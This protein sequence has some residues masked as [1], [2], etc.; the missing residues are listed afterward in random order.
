MS[1]LADLLHRVDVLTGTPPPQGHDFTEFWVWWQSVRGQ[2]STLDTEPPPDAVV[3]ALDQRVRRIDRRLAWELGP[4]VHRP[5]AL[6]VSPDGHDDLRPVTAAWRAAA[7]ADRHFDF[8]DTRP[9]VPGPAGELV[10][11]VPEGEIFGND[12]QV[13]VLDDAAHERLDLWVYH[14]ALK[15]TRGPRRLGLAGIL[16]DA[17]LGESD[18]ATWVGI[19][20]PSPEPLGERTELG[21]QAQ[22]IDLDTLRTRVKQ[23]A[24]AGDPPC[25][26]PLPDRTDGWLPLPGRRRWQHPTL[27]THLRLRLDGAPNA[28]S[29]LIAKNADR[30]CPVAW[31]ATS[32]ACF[33]DLYCRASG[34][35][36][37]SAAQLGQVA[38]HWDPGWKRAPGGARPALGRM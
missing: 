5:H 16:V 26:D 27:D 33:L 24:E 13:V 21:A 29:Q 1:L 7:P 28:A 12:V 37:R 32:R 38:L 4:G 31:R 3:D 34:P 6:T 36:P 22:I 20:R 11:E 23:R 8:L 25:P 35:V 18:S 9:P 17:A 10:L 14:P 15:R 2:L 30:I 19:L